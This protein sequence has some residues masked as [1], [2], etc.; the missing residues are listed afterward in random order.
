MRYF[1]IILILLS[2]CELVKIGSKNNGQINPNQETAIGAVYLFK[3]ELDS[4]NAVAASQLMAGKQGN[5]LLAIDR[6]EMS[7]TIERL[8]RIIS[9]K[10]ITSFKS[11]T[12]NESAQQLHLEFDY[13]KRMQFSMKKIGKQWFITDIIE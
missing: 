5:P 8:G 13:L 2:S 7:D 11:D 6:Y 9:G 1:F 4:N 10:N 3:A 12:L